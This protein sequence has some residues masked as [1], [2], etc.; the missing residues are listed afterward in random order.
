MAT[1]IS[2]NF[3]K[4]D[5]LSIEV[6]VP[7]CQSDKRYTFPPIT[8]IKEGEFSCMW[9]YEEPS[10]IVLYDFQFGLRRCTVKT[11]QFNA[12][13]GK[14]CRIMVET[15]SRWQ[16]TFSRPTVYCSSCG[17]NEPRYPS[18]AVIICLEDTQKPSKMP[19]INQHLSTLLENKTLSDIEFDVVGEKIAAHSLILAAGSPI[20][21]AVFKENELLK[22]D[23]NRKSTR[24]FPV[25]GTTAAVFRQL[26]QFMY[27]G[28]AP[29]LEQEGMA[30][31]LFEL[32]EK[33]AVWIYSKKN[34]LK[35]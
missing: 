3:W 11:I 5:I 20:M 26:L 29:Q 30:V 25:K 17:R 22:N 6:K 14:F 9:K 35:H 4:E 8:T 1:T 27:T 15:N 18:F 10:T 7:D 2:V 21:A 32:A 33:Y 23:E 19:V 31:Q 13:A 28:E 34:V 16:T 12:S 24:T